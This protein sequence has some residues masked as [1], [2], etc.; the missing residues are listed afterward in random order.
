[1]SVLDSTSV[2][3]FSA[4]Q[5]APVS[6]LELNLTRKPPGGHTVCPFYRGIFSLIVSL[7]QLAESSLVSGDV[8]LLTAIPS[9]TVY[10]NKY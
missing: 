9:R 4:T 2:G 10:H 7:S 8:R 1:M 6:F 5:I 3:I